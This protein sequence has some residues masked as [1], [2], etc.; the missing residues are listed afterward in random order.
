MTPSAAQR[1]ESFETFG[2][3]DDRSEVEEETE[4]EILDMARARN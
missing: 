3:E 1:G 2:A 4:Q